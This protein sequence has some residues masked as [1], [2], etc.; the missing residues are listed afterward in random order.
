VLINSLDDLPISAVGNININGT[1]IAAT[2]LGSFQYIYENMKSRLDDGPSDWYR[3]YGTPKPFKAVFDDDARKITLTSTSPGVRLVVFS[4]NP[5][6][7]VN[8]LNTFPIEPSNA[9]EGISLCQF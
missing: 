6:T 7:L 3:L 4:K 8:Y 1:D 2:S 9:N 5:I